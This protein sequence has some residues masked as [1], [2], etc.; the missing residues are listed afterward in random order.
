MGFSYCNF[1]SSFF[2]MKNKLYSIFVISCKC[3]NSRTQELGGLGPL[4]DHSWI[5][6][7]GTQGGSEARAPFTEPKQHANTASKL[8]NTP[9]NLLEKFHTA[10]RKYLVA[11]F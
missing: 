9:I 4:E 10:K 8:K 6:A 3:L 2:D 1:E 7:D 11:Y 5:A